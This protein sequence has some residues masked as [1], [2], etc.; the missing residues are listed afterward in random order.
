MARPIASIESYRVL[1]I[2][3][4]IVWHTG[5]L[6]S[7]ID[8]GGGSL[9]VT[10]TVNL[11]W[12]V[13]LPY[14]FIVAGYFFAD[15]VQRDGKPIA[16]LMRYT[17][18]LL[19]VF[20]AWICIYALVP[21]NVLAAVR[22]NGLLQPFYSEAVKNLNL[23]ASKHVWV[24]L[25]PKPTLGYL[26]FFPALLFS[27]AVLTLMTVYKLQRYVMVMIVFLYVV[28]VAEGPVGGLWSL[29]VL[30]TALG[31]WLSGRSQPAVRTALWMILGGYVLALIEGAAMREW[32]NSTANEISQHYFLGGIILALGI[33][34][35][36][37]A[38]P[39]LGQSTQL[40][41]LAKYTLGVY[42]CHILVISTIIPLA[43]RLQSRFVLWELLFTIA[44]SL[45]VYGLALLLTVTLSKFPQ[46]RYLVV[47]YP[48][49]TSTPS[50]SINI[51]NTVL[52]VWHSTWRRQLYKRPY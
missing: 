44:F 32:F 41:I 6:L 12:W 33:F 50:Q 15:S 49:W 14:F 3:G 28:A 17:S 10:I 52:G 45:T 23:L 39:N 7:L 16:H 24:F 35:L 2:L 40:P 38:K 46:A 9:L 42:V 47:K 8:L 19:W 51:T 48:Q 34:M 4:V 43:W 18:S 21:F 5:Y 22:D 13:S 20:L 30:F 11:V 1:A 29:A 31:W 25:E 26:W 27:L 36:T 37:L